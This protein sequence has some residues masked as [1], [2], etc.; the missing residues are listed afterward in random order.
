MK[1]ILIIISLFTASFAYGQVNEGFAYQGLLVDENGYG[2]E[3][4]TAEFIISIS[5]NSNE[6]GNIYQERQ[7]VMTDDNGV[8][9]FVIGNG[10]VLLGSMSDIDW[11]AAIPYVGIQ[12][13]LVDGNGLRD[14]GYTQFRS[15]PF[16]FYS[17]YVVCQ[18]GPKG[19]RGEHGPYG[20]VGQTGVTG[21]TGQKGEKG[22][23]GEPGLPITPM[24]D[25][26]PANTIL[27]GTIYLDDGTNREDGKPGFRYYDG[28]IWLD[29]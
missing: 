17:K 1:N 21:A 18:K 13:N 9:N 23:D 28:D 4:V 15:V 20:A 29:L 16:C 12:Y 25:T 11:L 14:L 5:S 8:F 27:E 22:V 3:N 26:I 24:L 10:E 7:E 2:I 19:I 6:N